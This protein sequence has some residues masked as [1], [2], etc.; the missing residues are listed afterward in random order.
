MR[1]SSTKKSM[2]ENEAVF[3]DYNE[4]IKKGFDEIKRLATEDNQR[5][6]VSQDNSPLYFYCE[7]SDENCRKRIQMKQSKYTQIH[8]NRDKFIIIPGHEVPSI[9]R[10]V[11]KYND[12]CVVEKDQHPT[13][14]KS[15]LNETDVDN[16]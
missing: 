14:P 1:N 6:F 3:R 5:A 16:T 13:L 8:K 7:C 11:K 4:R 15:G 2:I 9:E 10:I 12:Y